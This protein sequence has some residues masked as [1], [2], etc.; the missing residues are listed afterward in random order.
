ML[1]SGIRHIS[2]IFQTY[3]RHISSIS[4]KSKAYL[5]HKIR[6]SQA[7]SRNISGTYQPYPRC[8]SFQTYLRNISRISHAYYKQIFNGHIKASSQ[9]YPRYVSDILRHILGMYQN[10]QWKYLRYISALTKISY[11]LFSHEKFH[12]ISSLLTNII[13]LYGQWTLISSQ[14]MQVPPCWSIDWIFNSLVYQFLIRLTVDISFYVSIC[15][16]VDVNFKTWQIWTPPMTKSVLAV[17]YSA[18]TIWISMLILC[19]Y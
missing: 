16:Y 15:W 12:L 10:T 17:L 2:G 9:A 7:Y 5:R 8:T 1:V 6:I 3:L 4:C 14:L 19:F 13:T 18:L 11:C